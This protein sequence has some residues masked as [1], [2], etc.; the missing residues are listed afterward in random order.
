MATDGPTPPRCDPEIYRDGEVVFITSTIGS[1]A[2]EHWVKLV[3]LLSGQRVDW[4]WAGGRAVVSAIGDIEAV[5][6][7]VEELKP[8]HDAL[9]RKATA[10]FLAPSPAPET[11]SPAS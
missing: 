8:A 3:A 11:A 6:A 2:I 7:A 9:Y 5:K 4:H 1:N 10:K